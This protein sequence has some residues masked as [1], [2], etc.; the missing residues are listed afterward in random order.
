[1]TPS[2]HRTAP[3]CA[4]TVAAL[5][6]SSCAI[7]SLSKPLETRVKTRNWAGVRL[8][9][10]TASWRSAAG[11]RPSNSPLGAQCS[12]GSTRCEAL[13]RVALSADL[14]MKPAVPWPSARRIVL[15]SVRRYDYDRQG[16]IAGPHM[17]QG[18]ESVRTP[19]VQIELRQFRIGSAASSPYSLPT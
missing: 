3:M 1:M 9:R 4:L 12:L 16:R 2:L 17:E 7:C 11:R 15:P 18:A 13:D 5:I 14:A 8:P 19:H 10:Q 6:L